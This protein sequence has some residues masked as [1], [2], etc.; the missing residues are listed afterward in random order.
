M[1][2]GTHQRT[3][4][5]YALVDAD[6]PVQSL[7][8]IIPPRFHSD[9]WAIKLQIRSSGARVHNRYIHNR[10]QLPRVPALPDEGGPNRLF[11]ELLSLH[12]RPQPIEYPARDN[13]I[14]TDTWSLIDQRNSAL[15]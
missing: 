15:K 10:T 14:A 6:V 11:N 7:R 5:D 9:H 12:N 2:N 8:L 1:R 3:R 13:W 4:C